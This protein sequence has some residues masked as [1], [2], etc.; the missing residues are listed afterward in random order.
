MLV[1]DLSF[2]AEFGIPTHA[3]APNAARNSWIVGVVNAA[4]YRASAAWCVLY[5]QQYRL[6]QYLNLFVQRLLACGSSEQPF[7]SSR[8][9]LHHCIDPHRHTD[10]VWLHP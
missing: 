10:C 4:P 6:A 9:H 7:W 8:Y 3:G 5:P 1:Q 2:P